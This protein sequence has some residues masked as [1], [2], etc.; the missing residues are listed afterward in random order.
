MVEKLRQGYKQL[1]TQLVSRVKKVNSPPFN[2]KKPSTALQR[3]GP[4]ATPEEHALF[5]SQMKAHKRV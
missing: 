1:V 2:F 5:L 3:P 4:N